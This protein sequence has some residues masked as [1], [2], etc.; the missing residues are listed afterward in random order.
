MTLTSAA[1]S[2]GFSVLGRPRFFASSLSSEIDSPRRLRLRET[3][4]GGGLWSIA[5]LVGVVV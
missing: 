4:A 3:F 2:S 5:S 1:D